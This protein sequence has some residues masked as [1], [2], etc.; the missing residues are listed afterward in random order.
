M[1]RPSWEEYFLAMAR[2]VATRA[3][4]PRASI[5]AVLVRDKRVIATGYNGAPAGEVHCLEDGCIME[6]EHCQRVIHAEVNAIG[7]A[8]QHGISTTGATLYLAGDK[9]ITG[10]CRE[11][12]KV[13]VAAGIKEVIVGVPRT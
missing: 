3:T 11:C 7:Q 4:C 9:H 1:T 12:N 5:G 13:V 6:D 10:V 8:A 2:L